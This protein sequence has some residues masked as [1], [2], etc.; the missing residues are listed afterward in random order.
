M[1]PIFRNV[2]RKRFNGKIFISENT[3]KNQQKE[4]FIE[5]NLITFRSLGRIRRIS[6][7]TDEK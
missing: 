3:H 5:G 4:K 2:R 7:E 6:T 1:C